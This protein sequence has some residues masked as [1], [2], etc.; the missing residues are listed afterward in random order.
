MN[1]LL[2]RWL[3]A[4]EWRIHPVRAVVAM[5]AIALGVALGFAIHL[6]NAAAFNEFTAAVK[7]V[8]GVS[9]LQVRGP[10]AT[11]D[12][13]LFPRLAEHKGVALAS[14]VLELDAALP[15]RQ[16]SLKILGIDA[17]RAGAIAP[18]LLG[19][20]AEG[21]GGDTLMDDTIFLSPAAMEWLKLGAGD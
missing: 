5:G 8:S 21:H 12:E 7:S 9:D 19:V 11:M 13:A 16:G 17:F 6:I 20:P 1:G 4:G 3:L 18:D 10:Q 15:E 14:P 2:T